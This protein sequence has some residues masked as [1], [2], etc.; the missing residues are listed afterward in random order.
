MVA[1]RGKPFVLLG[2]N[3]DRD[4]DALRLVVA[5]ENITWR[6]WRDKDINGPIHTRWQ[7]SRRPAIH[8][9]D[10]QG[11]I[12]YRDIAPEEVDDAIGQLLAEMK[13]SK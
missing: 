7:V 5:K 8:L 3:S 11:V 10:A 6:S 1:M 12:R 4:L 2:V 9:L 13:K